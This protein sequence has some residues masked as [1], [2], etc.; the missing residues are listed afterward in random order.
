MNRYMNV[1][2]NAA[3]LLVI[4]AVAGLALALALASNHSATAQSVDPKRAASSLLT[5]TPDVSAVDRADYYAGPQAAAAKARELAAAVPLPDG[6][7]FNGIRW[8]VLEGAS[9]GEIRGLLAFNA[10][11]QWYRA[12]SEGREEAVADAILKD[13]PR[14]PTFRGGD[15]QVIAQTMASGT[16]PL[17]TAVTRECSELHDREVAYARSRGL[18]PGT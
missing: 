9:R 8:D 11:C 18:T 4:I 17:A 7:N 5:Q 13:V 16:G 12:R 10:A 2:R 6:G 15:R 14:W 3:L 1:N